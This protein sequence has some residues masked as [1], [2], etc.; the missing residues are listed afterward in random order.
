VDFKNF[1]RLK[2]ILADSREEACAIFRDI[3]PMKALRVRITWMMARLTYEAAY[4]QRAKRERLLPFNALYGPN[5]PNRLSA[6][7]G[8]AKLASKEIVEG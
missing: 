8:F 5:R 3:G 4:Y 7:C 6:I 1:I 2:L